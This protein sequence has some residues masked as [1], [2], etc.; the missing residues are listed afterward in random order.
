MDRT[1]KNPSIKILVVSLSNTICNE[2]AVTIQLKYTDQTPTHSCCTENNAS[3][4]R[5]SQKDRLDRIFLGKSLVPFLNL[6]LFPRH[7]SPRFQAGSR[8]HLIS[9]GL[10]LLVL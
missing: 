3:F 9:S 8:F 7:F 2:N 6:S 5:V 10:P 4:G 1:D